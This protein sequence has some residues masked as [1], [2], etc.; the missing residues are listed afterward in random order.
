MRR[1]GGGDLFVGSLS[2][3]GRFGRARPFCA[4]AME[5]EFD[6]GK[7]RGNRRD[8]GGGVSLAQDFEG[9]FLNSK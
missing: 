3:G 1:E 7:G 5:C 9:Q 2:M 8:G 6:R 4:P